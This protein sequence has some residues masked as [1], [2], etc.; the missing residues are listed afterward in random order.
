MAA[1]RL[2]GNVN[3][4]AVTI[5]N[6]VVPSK[7]STELTVPVLAVAVAVKVMPPLVVTFRLELA[8]VMVG[9]TLPMLTLTFTGV[10]STVAP[11]VTVPLA[12]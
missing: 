3:G 9:A 2:T 7:N 10:L 6:E 11:P 12:M 5:P 1:V 8:K 4:V